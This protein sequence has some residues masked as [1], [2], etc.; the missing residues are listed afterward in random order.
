[1][2]SDTRMPAS[3]Q[4]RDRPAASSSLA[5]DHVEAALGGALLALLGH[6]AGGMRPVASAIATISS[7]AAISKFSGLEMA[8]FSRAMSSSRI[9]RRSSRRCAVMPSHAGLDR[10]AARLDRIGRCAAARV[11]HGRDVVDVDAEAQRGWSWR[12]LRTPGVRSRLP[13]L[14]AGMAASSGGRASAG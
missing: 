13:G 8:A 2:N 7:V 1:M 14:T 11:P 6:E 3:A 5:A 9:W 4:L 12:R 10:R